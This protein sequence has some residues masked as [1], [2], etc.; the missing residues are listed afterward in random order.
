MFFILKIKICRN[1]RP[2]K[3]WIMEVGSTNYLLRKFK[4][5]LTEYLLQLHKV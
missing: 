1:A 5:Q 2:W 3:I 4:T